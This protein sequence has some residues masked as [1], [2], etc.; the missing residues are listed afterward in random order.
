M[1]DLKDIANEIRAFSNDIGNIID[2]ELTK[3]EPD[4]EE[5]NREQLRQG[6]DASG[7]STPN[8][9]PSTGKKGKIKFRETGTF[10]KSLKA[11]VK[12]GIIDLDSS[13]PKSKWL[14]PWKGI[15]TTIGLSPASMTRLGV[16]LTKSI[17]IR[18]KNI[19]N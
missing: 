6:K 7:K 11:E 19:F 16:M 5:L 1:K 18:I 4:I 3:L 17:E 8:Y 10:Y 14:N 9:K 15:L 2:Q 12:G 13:D